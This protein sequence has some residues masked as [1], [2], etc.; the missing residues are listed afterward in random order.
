LPIRD[1]KALISINQGKKGLR[2]KHTRQQ[3]GTREVRGVPDVLIDVSTDVFQ[4]GS[5]GRILF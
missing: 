5:N 2:E 4:I 3:S 1:K